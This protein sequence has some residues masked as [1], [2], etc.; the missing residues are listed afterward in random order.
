M[1]FNLKQHAEASLSHSIGGVAG[2]PV[3]LINPLDGQEIPARGQISR[4]MRRVGKES[5]RLMKERSE[6]MRV[7]SAVVTIQASSLPLVPDT[8]DS[9]WAMRIPI[10]LNGETTQTMFIAGTSEGDGSI[11]W[12]KFWLTDVEQ[13]EP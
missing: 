7:G 3:T 9:V 4:Q 6:S 2:E 8:D 1:V 13:V 11:G 12:L 10:E 5:R